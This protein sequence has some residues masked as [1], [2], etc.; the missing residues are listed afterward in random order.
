MKEGGYNWAEYPKHTLSGY[1]TNKVYKTRSKALRACGKMAG[2]K[3]VTKEGANKYRLNTGTTLKPNKASTAY[4]Q[5]S[6]L[7]ISQVIS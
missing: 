6:A 4:I 7:I 5:S 2:C 1:A 3:G